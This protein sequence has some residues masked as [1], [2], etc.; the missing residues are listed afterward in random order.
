MNRIGTGKLRDL[1]DQIILKLLLRHQEVTKKE[2]ANY[3]RLTVATVGT[4]L[5]DFLDNGT[6]VE[7]EI[8]YLKKGRPTKKIWIESRIFSFIVFICT[9]KKRQRLS[10]LANH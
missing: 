6:V 5:N 10:L 2:L 1:N 9:K 8:I 3:S 7:K 4:I